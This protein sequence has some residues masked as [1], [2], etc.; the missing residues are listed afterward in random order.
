MASDT[1]MCGTAIHTFAPRTS[2]L[3]FIFGSLELI[4]S[5]KGKYSMNDPNGRYEL[6][7]LANRIAQE[8]ASLG[9]D[10]VKIFGYENARNL[11]ADKLKR[12]HNISALI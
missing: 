1:Y 12:S 8:K 7:D 9:C 6:Y 11:V 3:R 10:E 5:A 2:L 4:E